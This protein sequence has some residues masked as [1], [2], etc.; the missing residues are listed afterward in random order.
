MPNE[1]L[2]ERVS[3]R[4]VGAY[5]PGSVSSHAR[6]RRWEDFRRTFPDLPDMH[7]VDV[8]GVGESWRLAGLRPARLTL[9]NLTGQDAPEDWMEIVVGDACDLPRDLRGD[10]VYCNSVIEHV[11][12]HWRRQRLAEG[13]H[14][15]AGRYWVQTPYRYFPIEPHFLCPGLQFL[16]RAAQAQ[17]IRRWP[18]GNYRMALNH[19]AALDCATRIELLSK[20]EMRSYF[21]TAEIRRE[22]FMGLTKSLIAV[23]A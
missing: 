12:G 3:D 14:R 2:A 22:R 11:G 8:G 5:R 15:V 4:V 21:P 16:P 17:V 6:Q 1:G 13:I 7:V 9:V 19:D 23:T 20:V 18:I 10:V